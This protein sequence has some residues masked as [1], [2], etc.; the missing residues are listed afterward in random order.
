MINNELE[1]RATVIIEKSSKI[2]WEGLTNPS[3]IKNYLY[4]TNTITTWEPGSPIVFEGE[5]EGNTYKDEGVVV[6][7]KPFESLQYS[8]WSGFSGLPNL[9][10]NRSL[11]SYE[12]ETLPDGNTQFSWIQKGFANVQ[13]YEHSKSN[14][15]TFMEGIK[16][17]IEKIS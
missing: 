6:A 13:G 10:E 7:F 5:W 2:V 8:Y 3:I 9:P 16:L 1:L 14:M 15:P 11:I 17:E 12:L 4:G